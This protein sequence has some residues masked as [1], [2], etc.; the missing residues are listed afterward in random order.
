MEYKIVNTDNFC[1]DYPDE[2]FVNVP[3]TSLDNARKIADFLNEIFNHETSPRYYTVVEQNYK[4]QP[5][6]EP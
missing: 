3:G 4:L 5:G 6:F 2:F 1:G